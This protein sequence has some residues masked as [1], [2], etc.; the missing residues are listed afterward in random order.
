MD[1]KKHNIRFCLLVDTLKQAV[2]GNNIDKDYLITELIDLG[3]TGLGE[4][5][6]YRMLDVL[7]KADGCK[8]KEV[9]KNILTLICKG[10]PDDY[11]LIDAYSHDY[12]VQKRAELVQLKKT[13]HRLE[14][15]ERVKELS[16]MKKKYDCLIDEEERELSGLKAWLAD[17]VNIIC[18][19]DINDDE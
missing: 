17:P 16:E 19:N 11:S 14:V 1:N 18:P 3:Q 15:I 8:I 9:C 5:L 4:S 7:Q 10:A 12:L 2:N 6:D 13:V